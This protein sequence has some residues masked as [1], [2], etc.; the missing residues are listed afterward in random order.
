MGAEQRLARWT[1]LAG[2]GF[3]VLFV[4][5]FLLTGDNPDETTSGTKVVSYYKDHRGRELVAF[6]LMTIGLVLLVFFAGRVRSV[7]REA[8][9]GGELLSAIFF[10][11]VIVLTAGALVGGAI[12]FALID[13][14][15]KG[16][17]AVA[18]T[19]NVLD[20][21]DFAPIAAGIA[22]LLLAAGIATVL[23]PVLPRWLGWAS[24]VIGVLNLTPLG[25]IFSL[26]A[27]VWVLVVS[28]LLA[29]GRGATR[30]S[31]APQSSAT[32]RG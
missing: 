18:H 19:L 12:H 5:G 7:L 32:G 21:N 1:A 27:V 8:E 25:F 4:V 11:G 15:D 31:T 23:S 2:V 10:G 24:I 30:A 22:I 28:I 3:F 17:V 13:A 20:N 14:A 6:V 9:P 26:L 29:G 16:Q